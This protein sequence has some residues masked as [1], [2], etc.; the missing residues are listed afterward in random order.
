MFI[1]TEETPNPATI[2]F[3][4]GREVTGQ[5]MADYKSI[6]EAVN[7][8]LARNLFGLSGVA[9]VMLGPDFVSVTKAADED[10][11]DALKTRIMAVMMDHFTSGLPAMEGEMPKKTEP[12]SEIARQIIAVLDDY[13][14]PY[15]SQHGGHI[16]FHDFDDENGVVYLSMQGA[17]SGCPSS[18]A[19]LKMGIE[20]MLKHYVPEVSA[21]EP[22]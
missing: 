10:W 18:T 11:S 14:T 16:D 5:G 19:T 13:V 6:D 22:I 15:V 8:I 9:G 17:C 21:V 1:Q 3:L 4:P 7:S 20:N 2:K 12:D